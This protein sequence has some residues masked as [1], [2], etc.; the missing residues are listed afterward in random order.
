[1]RHF[2]FIIL[3]FSSVL[4]SS[5]GEDKYYITEEYYNGVEVRTYSLTV[6]P[7]DW[8]GI[9]DYG[10]PGYFLEAAYDVNYITKNVIKEGAVL[11]YAIYA[12]GDILLP[13]V[14]TKHDG[15][16]FTEILSYQLYEG[17]I[18]FRIDDSDFHAE[19]PYNT[20][21]DFRIKVIQ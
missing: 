2:W 21:F 6:N 18:A 17:G 9:G 4:L 13:Y 12:D 5:C 16:T 19:P 7:N 20:S 3:L 11:V 10:Q 14:L 1:M 15:S 8:K